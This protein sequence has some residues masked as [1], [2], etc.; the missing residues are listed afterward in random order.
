MKFCELQIIAYTK[1]RK[2]GEISHTKKST[3]INS[4]LKHKYYIFFLS[5]FSSFLCVWIFEN[6]VNWFLKKLGLSP[7]N[8]NTLRQNI[9]PNSQP[10][11][12][13]GRPRADPLE[14]GRGLGCEVEAQPIVGWAEK[15]KKTHGLVFLSP[16]HPIRSPVSNDFLLATYSNRT[17]EEKKETHL[18]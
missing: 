6:Q 12:A 17:K 18:D 15:N 13:H 2:S 1:H 7:W 4:K 9:L 3:A 5:S 16:A 14:L 8:K 11:G 10:M